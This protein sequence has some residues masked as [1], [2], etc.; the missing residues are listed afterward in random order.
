M[1]QRR[2]LTYLVYSIPVIKPCVN[3]LLKLIDSDFD[4][5]N[6]TLLSFKLLEKSPYYMLV[7][8]PQVRAAQMLTS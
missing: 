8:S 7:S 4:G 5:S 1:D 3:L 6:E 2:D